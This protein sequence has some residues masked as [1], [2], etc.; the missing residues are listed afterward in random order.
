MSTN[1][2]QYLDPGADVPWC[3]LERREPSS[4]LAY[5]KRE[6]LMK[7]SAVPESKFS[8]ERAY[9]NGRSRHVNRHGITVDARALLQPTP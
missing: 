8:S 7:C 3:A 5:C 9:A 2:E 6:S 4:P 1:P